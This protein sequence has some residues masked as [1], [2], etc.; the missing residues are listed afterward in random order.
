MQQKN[1]K[2][3]A[4]EEC[5]SLG[6]EWCRDTYYPTDKNLWIYILQIQWADYL[7]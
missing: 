2:K 4:T 6:T 7:M 5:N 3:N 1:L